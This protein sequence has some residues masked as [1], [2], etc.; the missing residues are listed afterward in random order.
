M[1]LAQFGNDYFVEVTLRKHVHGHWIARIP[2]AEVVI[3]AQLLPVEFIGASDIE[4]L[5]EL[6]TVIENRELI[7]NGY[8]QN[9][10][11]FTVPQL[12]RLQ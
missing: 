7:L 8:T 1:T 10:R 2:N 5:N 9:E 3:D 11:R 6:M 4:A 12:T